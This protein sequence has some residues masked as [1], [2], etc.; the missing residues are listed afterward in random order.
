MWYYSASRW[1]IEAFGRWGRVKVV[2]ATHGGHVPARPEELPEQTPDDTPSLNA[3]QIPQ[4]R[5]HM[6]TP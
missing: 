1:R 3:K 5:N 2:S 6:M 4:A